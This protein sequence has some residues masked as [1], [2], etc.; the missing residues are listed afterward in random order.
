MI[1]EDSAL[2]RGL[3]REQSDGDVTAARLCLVDAIEKMPDD[4]TRARELARESLQL[5]CDQRG[6]GQ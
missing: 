6:N 4:A 3:D 5:L 1:D 2:L